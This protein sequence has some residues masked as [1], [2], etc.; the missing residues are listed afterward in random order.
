VPRPGY[1]TPGQA[2]FGEHFPGL[3][4]RVV[5]VEGPALGH[6]ASLIRRY[7]ADGLPI[8]YLVPPAVDGY[9]REHALYDAW[10][11]ARP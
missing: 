1:R 4:D 7:A 10:P 6:S 3:E 5:F 2:W 8:R 9:V 11:A